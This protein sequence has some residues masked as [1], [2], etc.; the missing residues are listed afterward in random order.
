[1]PSHGRRWCDDEAVSSR[2]PVGRPGDGASGT[3]DD[4]TIVRPGRLLVATPEL[5]EAT[6]TRTVVLVLDHD[7]EGTLGVVLN[8]P[9]T[10]DVDDVL[11]GWSVALTLPGGLYEGGPV[12]PDGA[13][14]V[15]VVRDPAVTPPGWRPMCGRV[16][17]VDLDLPVEAVTSLVAGVRIFAGYAGWGVDQ[18]DDEI[19]A[20]AWWVVD[21]SESD[22]LS[23]EPDLLWH[24]VLR[25][26]RD[27]LVL[28]ATYPDDPTMN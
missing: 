24:A 26:Q 6:F 21:G 20:G 12:V 23:P 27:E 4:R 28:L 19:A 15:A 14:G 3:G 9:T 18:L 13:L 7:E 16:G 2:D 10:T 22:L 25:R 1:M 8:R 11:P 17:L 5:G